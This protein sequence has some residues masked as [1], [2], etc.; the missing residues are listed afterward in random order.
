MVKSYEDTCFFRGGLSRNFL[1]PTS[2]SLMMLIKS[3]LLCT[4][5]K[6]VLGM[7]S[8][9]TFMQLFT[10]PSLLGWVMR[11]YLLHTHSPSTMYLYSQCPS[12]KYQQSATFNRFSQFSLMLCGSSC[13]IHL[14]RE[15]IRKQNN[16]EKEP[17]AY[18]QFSVQSP[19]TL[20]LFKT[21]GYSLE[22]EQFHK[23]IIYMPSN[24]NYTNAML[25]KS[26]QNTE[27]CRNIESVF[28]Y[29]FL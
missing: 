23:C 15:F 29:V 1:V 6:I 28:I 3:T 5:V 18:W 26:K 12:C 8:E 20:F 11:S 4:R 10:C 14:G 22:T 2:K 16:L 27:C 13:Y 24:Y 25:G 19:C 7:S 17:C 9:L 21:Q